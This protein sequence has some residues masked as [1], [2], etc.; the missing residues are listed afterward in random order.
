MQQ[1]HCG[2]HPDSL[3]TRDIVN[4]IALQPEQI[5][6]LFRPHP[7]MGRDLLALIAAVAGKVVK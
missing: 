5:G 7:H 2:F 3:N 6:N 4:R 1:G